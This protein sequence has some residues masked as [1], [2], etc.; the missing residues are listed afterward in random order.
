MMQLAE[1]LSH[2]EGKMLSFTYFYQ[3]LNQLGIFIFPSFLYAYLVSGNVNQYFKFKRFPTSAAVVIIMLSVYTVLPFLGY[4][5]QINHNMHLPDFMRG[6]E[7]WMREKEA[8]AADLTETFLKTKT[9]TGLLVN[10]VILALMPA[11]GEELLFRGTLQKIFISMTKSAHWGI[12]ITAAAFSAFHFQFLGFLPRFLLGLMLGYAMIMT[13]SLWS[14]IWLH[15]VNNA[16]TVVIYYL[17]YKDVLKIP[18]DDF[19][20]TNNEVYII[21]S[22]LLTLW[23]F[24][25][26]Y[27]RE[28]ADIRLKYFDKEV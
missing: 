4:L 8:Q 11:L 3:F 22:L 23:L 19:G 14:S 15:F 12:I 5:S 17:H 24:I 16:S 27:N 6:V 21:G 26:L 13:G 9:T 7:E 2:P 28:G 10:L 25:M 20:N 1:K 18:A